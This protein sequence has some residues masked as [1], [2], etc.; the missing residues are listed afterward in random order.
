MKKIDKR[1]IFLVI[2]IIL[3]LIVIALFI[4]KF[5]FSYLAPDISEDIN[6]K[7]E[8]TASGDTIIFNNGKALTLSATT[9]NFTTGGTNL[10][11]TTNPTAK[12]VASSKTNKADATYYVGVYIK[13][14]TYTYSTTA[15]TPEVLL[16]IK[17]EK[18]SNVTSVDGLTYTTS[19]G[20]SGFDVTDKTGLFNI[21]TDYPI[22]TTSS[23]TGTT[24][25]WT[26]TLTFVNLSTD[27]SV[28]ENA[29]MNLDVYLQK[30]AFPSTVADVCSGGETLA[31]CVTTLK[32]KD[33]LGISNI[34]YH[35]S[36]LANGAGD[37]SYRYAGASDA[38]NNYVCFGSTTPCQADNLYRIIGVFGDQVKLIKYDYAN[39]NLL[40]TDGDYSTYTYSKSNYPY[41]GELTTINSYYWN[42]STK[43]NTW[44]ESLLN[45][46]NL[47]TNF[48]TNIGA[49]W[50]AKIAETT[51]KVGGNTQ[52]KIARQSAKIAYQ[53]EIVNPVTTKTTDGATEY[54]A[55]IGLMYASDYG[56]AAAPSAWTT[57]LNDYD[58]GTAIINVNW[59]YLGKPEDWTI[60]RSADDSYGAFS[61]RGLGRVS[62]NDSGYYTVDFARCVRPSFNLLSSI[63]YVS[64]SG[65]ANDPIVIN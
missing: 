5:T 7:G 2:I 13:N 9:D 44:S 15:K 26:F 47:N 35:D 21:K 64:G 34:Y 57:N 32:Q 6:S 49:D 11:S 14:N 8:V 40:G 17:D 25:T 1:K 54:S 39:S 3:I 65:S 19:G 12:L 55:K 33:T 62:G 63:T 28:N 58:V 24:H 48:I 29:N 60:S 42:N 56:F 59:M 50:A 61:V 18:G 22:T 38:V 41:K 30:K 36:T 37:N 51:W 27:Q 16:T 31:S 20:V 10:T 23:T 4:G 45:K 46:T 52:D 53:N 43:K